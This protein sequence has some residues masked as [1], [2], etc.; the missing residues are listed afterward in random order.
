ML[1]SFLFLQ[2]RGSPDIVLDNVCMYMSMSTSQI[3]YI[4]VACKFQE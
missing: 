1:D 2:D 3:Y 4:I